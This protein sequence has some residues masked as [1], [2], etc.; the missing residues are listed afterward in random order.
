MKSYTE[1]AKNTSLI[2]Q[3]QSDD[4]SD[5][6]ENSVQPPSKLQPHIREQ[7]ITQGELSTLK[8]AV[9]TRCIEFEWKTDP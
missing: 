4:L 8:D 3:G 7:V 6:L 2:F 5:K 1:N 9:L